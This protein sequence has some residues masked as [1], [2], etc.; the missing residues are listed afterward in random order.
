MQSDI[1]TWCD[2]IAESK[3]VEDFR[4]AP[5]SLSGDTFLELKRKYAHPNQVRAV[6]ALEALGEDDFHAEKAGA[7]GGPITAGAGPV[8]LAGE[9]ELGDPVGFSSGQRGG[10]FRER[11]FCLNRIANSVS[12]SF[13]ISS[14]SSRFRRSPIQRFVSP[15]SVN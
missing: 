6:D 4:A 7:L 11:Y 13:D 1:L 3:H 12:S 10:R 8:F 5:K 14:T 2:L 9:D 15:V